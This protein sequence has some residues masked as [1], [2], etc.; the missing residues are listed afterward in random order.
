MVFNQVAMSFCMCSGPDATHLYKKTTQLKTFA[1]LLG[2][3]QLAEKYI[4]LKSD[5]FLSKGHLMAKSDHLFAPAQQS[6]F[7][8]SNAA[9]Q[10][11]TFNGAN[12]NALENAVRKLAVRMGKDLTCYTGT[13]VRIEDPYVS[14]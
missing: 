4:S 10:W 2:S 13:Y 5:H 8:Y 14:S 3:Q 6:T 11:Q 9:P 7:L 1:K 12:W